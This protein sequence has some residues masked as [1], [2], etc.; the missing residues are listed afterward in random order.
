MRIISQ[1]VI[2]LLF[3]VGPIAIL[4]SQADYHEEKDDTRSMGV[5]GLAP[6]QLVRGKQ[7]GITNKRAASLVKKHY[8]SSRILGVSLLDDKGPPV[9]RVRT[10][11]TNGVVKSVFV[12]GNSGE[13]FE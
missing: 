6:N 2:L 5:Q 12:D 3:T 13:V 11:S 1:L 9:Y 10:L 4:D 8:S 7:S